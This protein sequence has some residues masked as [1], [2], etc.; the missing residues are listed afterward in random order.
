MTLPRRRSSN[1][2]LAL[3]VGEGVLGTRGALQSLFHALLGGE[4]P[5]ELGGEELVKVEEF[6]SLES[7]PLRQFG[8]D[9]AVEVGVFGSCFCLQIGVSSFS[10]KKVLPDISRDSKRVMLSLVA[11]L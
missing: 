2:G 11:I 10:Q 8:R 1:A 4:E 7:D 5:Q 9:Q 3:W 6:E